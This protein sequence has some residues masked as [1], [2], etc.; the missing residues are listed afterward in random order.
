[1]S[2]LGPCLKITRIYHFRGQKITARL[3]SFRAYKS[4]ISQMWKTK[5]ED[6]VRRLYFLSPVVDSTSCHPMRSQED[7]LGAANAI[8]HG[9]RLGEHNYDKGCGCGFYLP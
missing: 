9:G 7:Q 8:N 4:Q 1:M 2:N 5:E 6:I 3:E